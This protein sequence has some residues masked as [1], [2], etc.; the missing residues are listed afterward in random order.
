LTGLKADGDDYLTKPIAM[1]ERTA[2][3]EALLRG[4][5]NAIEPNFHLTKR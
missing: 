4:S 5:N 2:R 3:A 1:G